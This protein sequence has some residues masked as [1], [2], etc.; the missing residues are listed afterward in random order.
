MWEP[1]GTHKGFICSKLQ[2]HEN[3]FCSNFD[4]DDPVMLGVLHLKTCMSPNSKNC[5]KISALNKCHIFQC[6]GMI[7]L[8]IHYEIWLFFHHAEIF[9]APR[10]K[11]SYMF[12]KL[13]QD[14]QTLKP[15]HVAVRNNLCML[16]WIRFCRKFC[17]PISVRLVCNSCLPLW[18]VFHYFVASTAHKILCIY[19]CLYGVYHDVNLL[20][21]VRCGN[22]FSNSF[23]RL[24]SGA[25]PIKLV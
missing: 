15:F 2:S 14:I 8:T 7:V 3:L 12:L 16:W 6:M 23:H 17:V 1:C 11:I 13:P 9:R 21:P 24:I 18:N 19:H 4:S 10:L 20:A 25:L 22:V 5:Y